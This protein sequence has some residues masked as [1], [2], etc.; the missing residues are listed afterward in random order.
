MD[1]APRGRAGS[2]RGARQRGVE[3]NADGVQRVDL[4]SGY[5][6]QWSLI[7]VQQ[8][9]CAIFA[10]AQVACIPGE[11]RR[12]RIS[13][14][15]YAATLLPFSVVVSLKL[16]VQNR[17]FELVS[18]AFY[19]MIAST[20][21]VGVTALSVAVGSEPFRV[22]TC[23]AAGVVA[24]EGAMIHAGEVALSPAGFALTLVAMSLD[25][26]RLVLVQRLVQPLG[27]S[28]VGLMLL[29]APLQCVI[30]AIGAAVLESGS[31]AAAARRG[32]HRAGLVAGVPQR[33]AR[34]GGQPGDIRLRQGGVRGGGGGDD[35]LQGPG[36]RDALGRVCGAAKRDD[37]VDCRLC[38]G[39]R[40]VGWGTTRGT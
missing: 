32:V 11:A 13:R 12:V 20:L 3:L 10:V 31:V 30:A 29:S 17:A 39:V 4:P 28:S 22:V 36:R 38:A 6:Y 8:M 35:A 24:L 23:V 33:R 21:P 5:H 25:V 2:P 9:V 1:V 37:D 40:R 7:V 26:T 15:D 34:G 27:L 16:Y 14:K 18:P 19:A